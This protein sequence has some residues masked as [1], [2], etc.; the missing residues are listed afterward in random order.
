MVIQLRD[1]GGSNRVVIVELVRNA[2]VLDKGL[3]K[4][5]TLCDIRGR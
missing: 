3:L 1:G 5:Y 4:A 2:Q